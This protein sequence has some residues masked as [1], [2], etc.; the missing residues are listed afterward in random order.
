[1]TY[2]WPSLAPSL[3]SISISFRSIW[4]AKLGDESLT[5]VVPKV[6]GYKE[7]ESEVLE[8]AAGGVGSCDASELMLV[9]LRTQRLLERLTQ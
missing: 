7:G 4:M 8:S 9:A 3:C 5:T 6:G 1:M 2:E